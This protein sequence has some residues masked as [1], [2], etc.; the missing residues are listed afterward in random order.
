MA[1]AARLLKVESPQRYLKLFKRFVRERRAQHKGRADLLEAGDEHVARRAVVAHQRFDDVPRGVV[2]PLDVLD[3]EQAVYPFRGLRGTLI[4]KVRDIGVAELGERFDILLLC[5]R[6]M[7]GFQ[8]THDGSQRIRLLLLP[9]VDREAFPPSFRETGDDLVHK[10]RLA[11]PLFAPNQAA[12]GAARHRAGKEIEHPQDL[13]VAGQRTLLAVMSRRPDVGSLFLSPHQRRDI[14]KVGFDAEVALYTRGEGAGR[15][16]G[17]DL[18]VGFY[19]EPHQLP[20]YLFIIGLAL[21]KFFI[22]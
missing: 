8:K 12:E 17:L 3:H 18:L 21:R 14:G 22:A 4:D 7:E 13:I 11:D 1:D 19:I 15:V 2:H 10:Y 16:N 9:A 5:G 20:V 6:D